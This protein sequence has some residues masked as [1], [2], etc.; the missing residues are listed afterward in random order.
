MI[1]N[2]DS[3][4]RLA[5]GTVQFGLDYG[6]SN[7]IGKTSGDEV[8]KILNTA[9]QFGINT[10][11][12][13]RAYG[14][15][16]TVLGKNNITYFNIVSK[17]PKSVTTTQTLIE[18]LNE[19][20]NHLK[21]NSLY[22]YM[23]HDADSLLKNDYL[24]DELLSLKDKGIVKKI[25]YSL[26][27]TEQLDAL[28]S[29]KYLPQIVQVPY[30]FLDR[31]FENYFIE[32]KALNCEIHTRSAF[33]QGLF[34]LNPSKLDPFFEP[35][36]ALLIE[37]KNKLNDNKSIASFLLRFVLKNK[38]VDKVVFGV[39]SNNELLDNVEQIVSGKKEIQIEFNN[40]IP[41]EILIPSFWP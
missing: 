2:L 9:S 36:K 41:N 33:L 6:I 16:E 31:R 15:S 8:I 14:D 39:T 38:N 32:L 10:I 37:L 40:I 29:K 25:G 26:Y 12:T 23:A 28:L 11:D 7:T 3:I 22:G 34:F 1:N 19:T 21:I 4:N 24:W 30:N 13:A 20:L 17:F 27:D 35:V 18:S 5:L